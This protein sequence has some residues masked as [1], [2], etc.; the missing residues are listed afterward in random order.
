[1]HILF[2]TTSN[3]ATNPRTVKEI[4]LA[5][6]QGMKVTL[7]CFSFDNWSKEIN[8]EIKK[9]IE[10]E[11]K[12]IELPGNRKPFLIWF[13]STIMFGSAR[14]V[15]KLFPRSAFWLSVSSN[16]RS[17]IL[18]RFLK[19]TMISPQLIVAHNVGSMYPAMIFS[20]RKG[21]RLGIDLEDYYPGETNTPVVSGQLRQL[22][23]NI[24][25]LADYVTAASPLIMEETLKIT[26]FKGEKEIIFNYFDRAEFTAPDTTIGGSLRLIWFSQNISFNRGLEQIAPVIE[27]LEDIELDIFG[28]CNAEFYENFLRGKRN[29]SVYDA[30][31]QKELH[32]V[33]SEYDA[34]LAIE[35]RKDRNNEL[36]VSN[37]LIAYFQ[38]GLYII[39]SDTPAQKQFLR[40]NQHSGL[41][42]S[43][44]VNDLD[45][46]LAAII[47]SKDSIRRTKSERFRN[48]QQYNWEAESEKLLEVWAKVMRGEG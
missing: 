7:L 20:K 27:Q 33:L 16:K 32:K 28:N 34:G 18:I 13:M 48:A 31:P 42:I 4:N 46:R 8:E 21:C 14:F 15:L 19:R 43:L 2:I 9:K 40:E 24:L 29:I 6:K 37:K 17:W 26:A 41:I 22:M 23:K 5:L 12:Y 45:E 25:P 35:P 30:L 11:I 39:A 44:H 10:K 1:M 38:A 36:A 3:L 47:A